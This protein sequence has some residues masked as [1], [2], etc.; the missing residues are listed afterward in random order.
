MNTNLYDKITTL[1]HNFGILRYSNRIRVTYVSQG[2]LILWDHAQTPPI[3]Y[4]CKD[5][6]HTVACRSVVTKIESLPK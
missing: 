1:N 2:W 5:S 6:D 3:R 4:D